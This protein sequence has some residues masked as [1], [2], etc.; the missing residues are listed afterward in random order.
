L[1]YIV[2]LEEKLEAHVLSRRK[3]KNVAFPPPRGKKRR[4]QSL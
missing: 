4:K 3:G 2:A 1:F